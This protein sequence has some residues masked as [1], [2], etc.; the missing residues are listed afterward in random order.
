MNRPGPL[1]DLPLQFYGT[2]DAGNPNF[3]PNANNKRPLSPSSR[4]EHHTKRRILESPSSPSKTPGSAKSGRFVEH[5]DYAGV[6]S[7]PDSPARALNFGAANKDGDIGRS[8]R[9]RVLQDMALSPSPKMKARSIP[10]ASTS[11]P[12]QPMEISTPPARST[13][14]HPIAF[15]FVPRLLP[16]PCDPDS[17]HYPGFVVHRDPWTVVARRDD[18]MT[19]EP[20][21]DPEGDLQKENSAPPREIRNPSSQFTN[22]HAESKMVISPDKGKARMI[23]DGT[24]QLSLNN[25]RIFANGFEDDLIDFSAYGLPRRSRLSSNL[26]DDS[27]P[28]YGSPLWQTHGGG[29]VG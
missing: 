19:V 3:G 8:P 29:T 13:L 4:G 15:D 17:S 20:L 28:A 12:F 14:E 11:S 22:I 1:R 9:S 26:L 2:D 16:P 7:G 21:P 25:K 27:A 5:I 23:I 6:L 18:S 10:K 24:T